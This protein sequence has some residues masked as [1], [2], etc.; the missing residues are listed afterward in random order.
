[1]EIKNNASASFLQAIVMSLLVV[2]YHGHSNAQSVSGSTYVSVPDRVKEL[3]N[4]YSV[5]WQSEWLNRYGRIMS[6]M[7]DPRA[8]TREALNNKFGVRGGGC[9][10]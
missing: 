10:F 6:Q 1:M 5:A 8:M 4:K 7:P 9:G 2:G 3:E